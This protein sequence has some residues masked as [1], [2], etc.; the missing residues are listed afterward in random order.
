MA[1]ELVYLGW[2]TVLLLVYMLVPSALNAPAMDAAYL[3]GPRDEQRQSSDPRYGRARRALANFQE[4]Y[5]AF[6]GLALALAF[7]NKTG[8]MGALGAALWFWCRVGYLPI[9]IL[10]IPYART[11]IWVG[12]LLGLGLMLVRLLG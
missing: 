8:G 1:T 4:T 10:G 3:A 9:Y 6:I 7:T 5:P 2:S 12:S 11:L